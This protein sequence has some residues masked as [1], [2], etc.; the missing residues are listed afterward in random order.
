M[1]PLSESECA[2]IIEKLKR[3]PAPALYGGS[4]IKLAA[5]WRLL[6]LKLAWRKIIPLTELL[7]PAFLSPSTQNPGMIRIRDSVCGKYVTDWIDKNVAAEYDRVEIFG[8]LVYPSAKNGK[9]W[10]DFLVLFDQVVMQD[11]YFTKEFLK[12]DSV[13]IDGGAN[14]GMFSLVASHLTPQGKVYAFE[15]AKVTC[16]AL[17]QNTKDCTNV[18]VFALGLGDRARKTEMMVHEGCLSGS[19][20]SDSGMTLIGAEKGELVPEEVSITTIDDFVQERKLER[21]NFIKIDAEGYEKQILRG[22]RETIRHFRPILAVSAYHFPND[23]TDIVNLVQGTSPEY[24][25]RLS[26]RAEE[27]LIFLPRPGS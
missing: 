21:L 19:T 25:H 15:P 1:K 23:K 6:A 5:V 11:Q 7:R 16:T 27:D 17:K 26:S 10:A 9:A 20:I 22:A 14:I 24:T 18:E 8:K 4:P 2:E 13:V 12:P 3:L